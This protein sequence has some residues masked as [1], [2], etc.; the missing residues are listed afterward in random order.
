MTW[1]VA[2]TGTALPGSIDEQEHF[3]DNSDNDSSS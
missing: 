3:G 1:R 2:A